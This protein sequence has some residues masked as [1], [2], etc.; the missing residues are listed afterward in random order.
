MLLE[1]EACAGEADVLIGGKQGDQAEQQT[2]D[3]LNET[4]PIEAGPGPHGIDR[5]WRSRRWLAGRL[6]GIGHGLGG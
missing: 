3:G 4:E 1:L 6:L 2:T 5:F